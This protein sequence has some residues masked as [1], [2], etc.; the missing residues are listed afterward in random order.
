M[1]CFLFSFCFSF[2]TAV[3]NSSHALVNTTVCAHFKRLCLLSASSQRRR[4]A[5]LRLFLAF[6]SIR[7]AGQRTSACGGRSHFHLRL[8][9]KLTCPCQRHA[10][11]PPTSGAGRN[12]AIVQRNVS[13]YF[14]LYCFG[15]A[16][17]NA[18][19]LCR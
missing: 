6:T 18:G 1:G 2:L 19:R 3:L 11:Y 9:F 7:R 17:K 16:A 12:F 4:L 13:T 10:P 15:N 14:T 8:T 5:L